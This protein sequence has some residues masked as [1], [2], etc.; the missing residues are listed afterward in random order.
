MGVAEVGGKTP[1]EQRVR[2]QAVLERGATAG[3]VLG[4]GQHHLP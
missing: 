2:W 1:A 3:S 4:Y